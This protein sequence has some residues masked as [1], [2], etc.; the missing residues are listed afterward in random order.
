MSIPVVPVD[1][2]TVVLVRHGQPVGMPWQCFMVRR[3][4]RSE[5]AADVFVF[6]G[7][8]VDPTDRDPELGRYVEGHPGP[9]ESDAQGKSDEWRVLRLSAIRELFE[10]AGVLLAYR[11]DQRIL[12]L[13][14]DEAE[15]FAAYRRRLHAGELSLLDLA[16]QEGLCYSAD[17][18]HPFSR[19]ITPIVSPRRY[20]TRFFV[21]QMPHGQTPLH[22]AQETTDSAWIGPGEALSR[23]RAGS[24]PLVYATEKHLERLA[25]YRSIEQ[26]IAATATA[27][28]QPIMPRVVK[29]DGHTDFLLPGEEGY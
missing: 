14:G 9:G 3:H 26:L 4:V 19:W 25:K 17:R 8:K 6:P 10:E 7:G 21:A 2:S 23:Y 12:K 15:K 5:F 24:F 13:Q 28:L 1:A 16:R 18:L 20:D 27:D 22:D 29:K 11:H